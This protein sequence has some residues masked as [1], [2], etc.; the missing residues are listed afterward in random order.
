MSA[1]APPIVVVAHIRPL[2]E[3]RD[4]V[5]ATFLETIE[6]VHLEDAGCELYAL[7]VAEDSLVMIEKWSDA[8]TFQAHGSGGALAAL[9]G[10]L[11][12][13]LAGP[14]EVTRM[15]PLVAGDPRLGAI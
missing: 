3:H 8:E 10:R 6:R 9:R 15:H 11:G 13:K 14:L 1:T 7:H 2:P 12:G 5:I 4:E